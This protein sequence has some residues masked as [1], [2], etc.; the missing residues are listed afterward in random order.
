MYILLQASY[1]ACLL[2]MFGLDKQMHKKPH[3]KMLRCD[4]VC[5]L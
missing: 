2:L 1:A 4:N 3:S 5:A